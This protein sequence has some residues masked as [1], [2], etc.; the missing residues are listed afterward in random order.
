MDA[1]TIICL[2]ILLL[3]MAVV[4][5]AIAAIRRAAAHQFGEWLREKELNDR[6]AQRQEQV[7][8]EIRRRTRARADRD[9]VEVQA[10]AQRELLAPLPPVVFPSVYFRSHSVDP[11]GLDAIIK[12]SIFTGQI[13]YVTDALQTAWSMARL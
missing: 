4:A 3:W 11:G 5:L 13:A 12:E 8:E 9:Y 1:I 10:H 2:L 6:A 7:R